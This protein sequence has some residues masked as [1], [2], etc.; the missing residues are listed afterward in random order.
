MTREAIHRATGARAASEAAFTFH[1]HPVGNNAYATVDKLYLDAVISAIRWRLPSEYRS[2]QKA[3]SDRPQR[4]RQR[5]LPP[6]RR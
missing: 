6:D 2:R 1:N 4:R 5:G 3:G